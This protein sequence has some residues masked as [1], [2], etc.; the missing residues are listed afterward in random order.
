MMGWGYGMMGG[1]FGMF[2]Q[3]V[4]IVIIVYAVV[5]LSGHKHTGYGKSY[6]NS[7]DILNERFARGEISEEEYERKKAIIMK[8]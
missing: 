5:R 3:F 2:I 4:L 1:W 8:R 6:D 7:L